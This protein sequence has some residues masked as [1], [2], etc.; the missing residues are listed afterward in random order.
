ME[1]KTKRLILA[2]SSPRR[3]ELLVKTGIIFEIIPSTFEEDMKIPISPKELAI[4]LSKGKAQ[5]VADKNPDAVVIG[6]D[7]FVIF[8]DKVLGK[9]HTNEKAKETLHMLS[10]EEHSVITGFTIIEKS[11]NKSIS[12]TVE[13]KVWFKD[14][15]EKE[16]D[17]YVDT[18]EPL[19]KGGAYAIQGLGGKLIEKIEGDR[20]NMIGLPINDVLKTLREFGIQS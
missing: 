2:S 9:P 6:A 4:L 13:T 11:A 8:G 5:S 16:I 17:E 3:K 14:L 10:G 15:S 7:T 18:G 20:S 1:L 19:D 12:K